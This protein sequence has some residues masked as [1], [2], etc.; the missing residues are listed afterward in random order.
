MYPNLNLNIETQQT[1]PFLHMQG[2]Q[3]R[4]PSLR[5]LRMSCGMSREELSRRAGVRLCRVDWMERGIESS[6]SDVLKVLLILTGSALLASRR[7]YLGMRIKAQSVEDTQ[8]R[9]K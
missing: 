2:R 7:G 6:L 3:G 1:Q 9:I 5:E 4:K 8:S